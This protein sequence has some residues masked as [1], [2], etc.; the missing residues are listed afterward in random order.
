MSTA[1]EEA[2]GLRAHHRCSVE[3]YPCRIDFSRTACLETSAIGKST[4][5]SRLHSL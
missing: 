2:S 5:A 1:R 4:L 3:G